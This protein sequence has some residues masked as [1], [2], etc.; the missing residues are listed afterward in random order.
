MNSHHPLT[1]W[2]KLAHEDGKDTVPLPSS[3]IYHSDVHPISHVG[4]EA[5][6]GS[7]VSQQPGKNVS[8]QTL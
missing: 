2:A 3:Q 7:V 1:A 4:A 8:T 5:E 6:R